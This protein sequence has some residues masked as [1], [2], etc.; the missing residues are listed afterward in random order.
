M[1]STKKHFKLESGEYIID[2][3]HPDAL[4]YRIYLKGKECEDVVGLIR[5]AL[6]KDVKIKMKMDKRQIQKKKKKEVKREWKKNQKK[7]NLS[8]VSLI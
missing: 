5:R 6:P 1:K 2:V 8:G 3:D 7:I 4:D